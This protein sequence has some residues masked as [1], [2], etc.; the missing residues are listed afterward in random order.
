MWSRGG[1]WQ[2]GD[3]IDVDRKN[4]R[5]NSHSFV[6]RTNEILTSR[7]EWG[8][9]RWV[10]GWVLRVQT[11]GEI[12]VEI[13]PP[14]ESMVKTRET[15][16][17]FEMKTPCFLIDIGY[18]ADSNVQCILFS[19]SDASSP[20]QQIFEVGH[21]PVNHS[22]VSPPK[23]EGAISCRQTLHCY[24]KACHVRVAYPSVF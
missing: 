1:K 3:E 18:D 15:E 13:F 22:R 23:A 21:T 8:H 17:G 10:I 20:V 14:R 4:S 2:V 9:P 5:A 11:C 19:S 7:W 6:V 24:S 12:H 16:T